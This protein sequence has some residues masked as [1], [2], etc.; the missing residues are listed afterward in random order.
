M[1]KQES[2]QELIRSLRQAV[3]EVT[4]V[5]WWSVARTATWWST[6]LGRRGCWR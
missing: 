2:I 4:G 6:A 1:T 5:K 3:P